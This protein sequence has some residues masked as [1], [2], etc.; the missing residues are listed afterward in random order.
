MIIK[1]NCFLDHT[2]IYLFHFSEIYKLLLSL[3]YIRHITV[4]LLMHYQLS[5][6]E[7]FQCFTSVFKAQTKGQQITLAWK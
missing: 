5:T 4:H 1:T 6:K 2:V 3:V 7:Q